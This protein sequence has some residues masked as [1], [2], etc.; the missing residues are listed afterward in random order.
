M[1]PPKMYGRRTG[2]LRNPWNSR[3]APVELHPP[4]RRNVG[5]YPS[6]NDIE[7]RTDD[8]LPSEFLRTGSDV[9]SIVEAKSSITNDTDAELARPN[10]VG[11][12][13][14]FPVERKEKFQSQVEKEKGER[15]AK[16][17]NVTIGRLGS[18]PPQTSQLITQDPIL[19]DIR[20]DTSEK[21]EIKENERTRISD[22]QRD[23]LS[24]EL[25]AISSEQDEE[26]MLN[27]FDTEQKQAIQ[28]PN[29]SEGRVPTDLSQHQVPNEPRY[30]SVD[31]PRYDHDGTRESPLDHSDGASQFDT[32]ESEEYEM[33]DP[34]MSLSQD[35]DRVQW[36]QTSLESL[37]YKEQPGLNN[38]GSSANDTPSSSLYNPQQESPVS[39]KDGV[40]YP[41]QATSKKQN[42]KKGLAHRGAEDRLGD[43]H[44]RTAAGYPQYFPPQE[45][46]NPFKQERPNAENALSPWDDPFP[47]NNH[48]NVSAKDS[49]EPD[50]IRDGYFPSEPQ[51]NGIR[52]LDPEN[53]SRPKTQG[54]I[55]Y[56]TADDEW[57]YLRFFG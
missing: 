51:R 30:D 25:K 47:G 9:A 27:E 28:P 22:S 12:D 32:Q 41:E 35:P 40:D 45:K 31:V 21:P 50:V 26:E 11:T 33:H 38:Q 1:G 18:K 44:S 16:E 2:Y 36:A 55:K 42:Y 48:V 43:R 54:K 20:S 6:S 52:E 3:K 49:T 15:R 39:P 13:S 14:A 4:L 37:Q 34:Y 57:R 46:T 23:S 10:P 56:P 29:V 19:Q 8:R 7:T 24:Q 5:R 17:K 53:T